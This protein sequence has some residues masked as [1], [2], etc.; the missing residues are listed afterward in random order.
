MNLLTM[1]ITGGALVLVIA[2]VRSLAMGHLPKRALVILWAVAVAR[3]LLPFELPSPTSAYNLIPTA[4]VERPAQGAVIAGLSVTQAES[5]EAE[6]GEAGPREAAP[7]ASSVPLGQAQSSTAQKA[8]P[9]A[10]VPLL[11]GLGAMGLALYFLI[12]HWRGCRRYRA[13]LPTTSPYAQAWLKDHP[14]VRRLS[15]R[16][17]DQI[18]APL[19]YGILRPVI[20]LPAA[21]NGA[22]ETT[23]NY[24]LTHEWVHIKRF[25]VAAK[26]LLAATLCLHWF[27]PL[28]WALYVLAGRDIELSCDEAVVRLHGA[29][30]RRAYALTLLNLES[31]RGAEPLFSHFSKNAIE[32]RIQAIMKMKKQSLAAAVLA[33]ALITGTVSAFATSPVSAPRIAQAVYT[34]NATEAQEGGKWDASASYARYAPYGLTYDR[35]GNNLYYQGK[36]VRVFEDMYPVGDGGYAGQYG[37][38]LS[39]EID[40]VAVRDLSQKVYNEDGS[41]DPSGVLIGLRECTPEEYAHNTQ[42]LNAPKAP[43]ATFNE[44]PVLDAGSMDAS[45]IHWW[46]Y[47][48]YATWLE[49]EKKDL[50]A[51]VGTGAAAWTRQDGWFEWTQ[52]K[53]DETIAM[54][55]KTLKDIE[56]GMLYA[57][58]GDTVFMSTMPA[59]LQISGETGVSSDN[60]IASAEYAAQRDPS[61]MKAMFAPYAHLGLEVDGQGALWYEGQ[62]VRSFNDT[63]VQ[64]LR[65][66]SVTNEDDQGAIDVVAV[67]DGQNQLTGLLIADSV[68]LA[69]EGN[70]SPSTTV[71]GSGN[72]TQ[73][74]SGQPLTDDELLKL[75]SVYAPYGLSCQVQNGQMLLYFQG[76]RVRSFLD[77]IDWDGGYSNNGQKT[78]ARRQLYDDQGKVDVEAQRDAQGALTGVKAMN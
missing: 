62:R 2:L 53:V 11:Y 23:L 29:Q 34:E 21:L 19:T 46:T 51:L 72:V 43:P 18:D 57:E 74:I 8:L 13:S 22:D 78:G 14:L 59:D 49:Q 73:A 55:E 3:L 44:A 56:N 77:V 58:D 36:L 60:G 30:S 35:M 54:Y 52:E 64:N 41:E 69:R 66:V 45:G 37:Q 39:G 47:D 68:A 5:G 63:Y 15:V 75:F 20:L 50:Q 27:N 16:R 25:D 48:E 9:R 65:T 7:P 67:R 33:C 1:S 28:A 40:V 61:S 71:A 6:S 42:R 38:N 17:S 24:V 70:F 12:S 31:Q 26:W 32:E 10:L 76:E 4:Q